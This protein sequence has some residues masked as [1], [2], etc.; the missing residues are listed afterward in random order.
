MDVQDKVVYITYCID[1]EGPLYESFQAKFERLFDLFGIEIEATRENLE[2]LKRKEL[3]LKGLEDAVA[4][5]FSDH[6]IEYK[7]TWDKLDEMLRRVMAEDFRKKIP[8]SYGGGWVFN[9]FCVDHVD[10][11]N[12]PRRRDLGYHNIYDHYK[13]MIRETQSFE[14]GIHWHFHPMSTYRDAHRCATSY[15]NSPHLLETLC[16]RIVDRS[17]FPC[18]FRAGFQAERPDSNLFLEQWIPF[19]LTNMAVEEEEKQLTADFANGRSGDWRLAPADWSIYHPHHDNYQLV[20]NCRRWIARALN[21]LNRVAGL[22]QVEVD[23]AFARA[24]SGQPTLMGVACHDYRELAVEVD[25]IQRLVLNSS[26]RFPDVKF[27]YSEA[28]D[29]FLSVAYGQGVDFEPL[30]LDCKLKRNGKSMFLEIDTIKGEVFGPQPFLAIKLKSNRYMHDNFDFD[31][32]L[33]KWFYT[34]DEESIKPEDVH[35][36]GVAANDKYGTQV[37]KNILVNQ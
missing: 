19:D 7:D 10:Y 34:F 22:T 37:V 2:K 9:W 4:L 1:T 36:I 21:I 28:K 31:P 13:D 35:T 8:D 20:G 23:K 33:S 6:L 29:A 3:D 32:S 18:M 5:V 16:R 14:D 24:N 30:E 27:K 25:E 12:N 26:K 11:V 17:W 15:V